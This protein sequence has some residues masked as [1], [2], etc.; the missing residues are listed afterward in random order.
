MCVYLSLYR[1]PAHQDVFEQRL[2]PQTKASVRRLVAPGLLQANYQLKAVFG[3]SA[4]LG[5]SLHRHQG[6]IRS[7]AKTQRQ[8]RE[9]QV[10]SLVANGIEEMIA[11]ESIPRLATK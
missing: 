8:E 1:Q 10:R 11:S 4:V 7:S 5:N 9:I 2:G 3:R 6:L